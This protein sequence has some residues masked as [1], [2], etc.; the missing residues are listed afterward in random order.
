MAALQIQTVVNEPTAGEMEDALESLPHTLQDAFGETLA[1]IQSQHNGRKQLGMN[2]LKIIFHAKCSLRVI[3]L[4][5]ALAI[6]SGH[7]S[8]NP[9]YRPSQRSIVESCF[10]LVIVDEETSIV[11]LVHY[12]IQEYLRENQTEVFPSGEDE[13]AER[14]LTY[15]FFDSFASG[16]CN[17]EIDI[18]IRLACNPFL[19]YAARYWGNHTQRSR[20]GKVDS[21]T[22]KLLRSK[23]RRSFLVQVNQFLLG[24]SDKYWKPVEVNSCN[25]LY[26]ASSFGLQ[27][28]ARVI[29]DSKEVEADA[30]THIGTTALICAA[31]CGHVE[32]VRMLLSEHADP[33][34]ANWYGTALHCAAEAGQ[35]E[36]I[37]ELLKTGMDVDFRSSFG[38]TPMQC[39]V[40]KNHSLA[41]KL[42]L[43]K[44]ADAKAVCHDEIMMQHWAAGDGFE[45]IVRLLLE[46]GVDIEATSLEG[47]TML[48]FAAIEG[49][50]KVVQMLI[51]KKANIEAR[52]DSDSTALSYAVQSKKKDT[53]QALLKSG[54]DAH[55]RTA[56][57]ETISAM[58]T[59]IGCKDFFE[60][61]RRRFSN[62]DEVE[63]SVFA[64]TKEEAE[65]ERRIGEKLR[66]LRRL[67]EAER[68][69]ARTGEF[70]FDFESDF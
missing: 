24:R 10:G 52:D 29:L 63:K 62:P 14:C 6:R 45:E 59:R 2:T 51:E 26:V 27:R 61:T 46:S 44:G 23:P 35:G 19:A 8:L 60:E 68:E 28:A 20:D 41:V 34:K 22:L 40:Q 47:T 4:S 18:R 66:R 30:E 39:A 25:Q 56:F 55:A 67:K 3:E 1:R 12:T 7:Y 36:C 5:E 32:L 58:A 50:T 49:R 13:M 42:L 53:V 11:R 57:G 69:S 43:E 16:C 38:R 33:I 9:R 70:V 65:H 17:L 64:E 37:R 54:A 21:L 31:A 48:H 15:L